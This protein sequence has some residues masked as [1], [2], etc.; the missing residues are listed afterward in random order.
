MEFMDLM[1]MD[2]LSR[3]TTGV[4]INRH[5]RNPTELE[6]WT[7]LTGVNPSTFEVSQIVPHVHIA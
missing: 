4:F 6:I 1:K 7:D 3:S 5:G 2:D